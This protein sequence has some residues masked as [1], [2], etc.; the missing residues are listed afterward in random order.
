MTP[1]KKGIVREKDR[2]K[3]E[4][5]KKKKKGEKLHWD[6]IIFLLSN[7]SFSNFYLSGYKIIDQ[8]VPVIS[9]EFADLHPLK[10][11]M[12]TVEGIEQERNTKLSVPFRLSTSQ[13]RKSLIRGYNYPW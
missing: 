13:L 8:Q 9:R 1:M 4:V 11:E 7:I 6:S 3:A 2:L 5:G 12:N 10:E